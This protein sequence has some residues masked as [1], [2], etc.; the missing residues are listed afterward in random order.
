MILPAWR[1]ASDLFSDETRSFWQ[2]ASDY[3]PLYVALHNYSGHT[4]FGLFHHVNPDAT[5]PGKNFSLR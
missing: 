5:H 4:T 2:T 1:G 3:Q